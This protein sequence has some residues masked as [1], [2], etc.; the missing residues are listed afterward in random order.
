MR[1]EH[2]L[3]TAPSAGGTAF[4][5]S[6][7]WVNELGSQM[8]IV[9]QNG[10]QLSGKY[11]SFV[12]GGGGPVTGDL[13]GWANGLLISVSVNWAPTTA[14]TSWVGQLVDPDATDMAIESLWQMTVPIENPDQPDE[15]W[16]SIL[17]GADTFRRG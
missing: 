4:D 14:I 11:T 15:L 13:V 9:S 8:D 16:Q 2:A 3:R 7:L 10:A 1:H 6:G 5:F 12:S 17:A